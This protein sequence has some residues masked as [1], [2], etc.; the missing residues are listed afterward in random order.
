VTYLSILTSLAAVLGLAIWR[1]WGTRGIWPFYRPV[2]LV[3][4]WA[5]L[6]DVAQWAIGAYAKAGT[7]RPY[8]GAAALWFHAKSALLLSWPAALVGVVLVTMLRR[9]PWPAVVLWAVASA[10]AALAYPA[11]RL[12]P[13]W[14]F[15]GAFSLTCCLAVAA[16][17]FV[18][19]R[20]RLRE[21]DIWMA[22]HLVP[23]GLASGQLSAS[24]A[25]LRGKPLEDWDIW[26]LFQGAAFVVVITYELWVLWRNRRGS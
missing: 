11:L 2:A 7:A 16:V 14:W 1:G 12:E 25:Y 5:P 24:V 18:D 3:L 4:L 13:R 22:H 20:R 21:G 15:Y 9:R 6:H 23:L 8:T 19:I 26:R 10:A 17:A